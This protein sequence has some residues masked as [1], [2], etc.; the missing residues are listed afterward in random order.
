[1]LTQTLRKLEVNGLVERRALRAAPPGME[2]RLT[3]LGGTLL[4]PVRSLSRWAE[5]HADELLAAQERGAAA[6]DS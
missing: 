3:P 1:M 2:Y 5:E 6:V 4:E